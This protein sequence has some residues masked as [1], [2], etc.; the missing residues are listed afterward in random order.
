MGQSCLIKGHYR[1]GSFSG[2]ILPYV[3][4]AGYNE[5]GEWHSQPHALFLLATLY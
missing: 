5:L 2:L 1:L 4:D 3:G